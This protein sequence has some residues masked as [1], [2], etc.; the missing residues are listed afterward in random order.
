M[1]EKTR[2]ALAGALRQL[3]TGPGSVEGS[4]SKSTLLSGQPPEHHPA[5][6]PEDETVN[7]ALEQVERIKSTPDAQQ[8]HY[9]IPAALACHVDTWGNPARRQASPPRAPIDGRWEMLH[10][11]AICPQEDCLIKPAETQQGIN[12]PTEVLIRSW[13]EQ[14]R[15]HVK[16]LKPIPCFESMIHNKGS[17]FEEV[18]TSQKMTPAILDQ[19]LSQNIRSQTAV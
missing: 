19:D 4:C 3:S 15:I 10:L 12:C 6:Q 17:A 13:G 14:G 11:Y 1:T 9:T 5:Q 7:I 18:N 2:S 8:I 16:C